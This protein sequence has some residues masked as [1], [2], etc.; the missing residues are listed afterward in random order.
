MTIIGCVVCEGSGWLSS[1]TGEICSLCSQEPLCVSCEAKPA[2]LACAGEHADE[3]GPEVC[4]LCRLC[5]ECFDG[6][7]PKE[8]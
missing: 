2:T 5:E 8:A 3:V 4:S 6:W 7:E 1:E